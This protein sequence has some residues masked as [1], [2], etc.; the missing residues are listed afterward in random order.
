MARVVVLR[1]DAPVDAGMEG[2]HPAAKHLRRTGV[3]RHQDHVQA[4]LLEHPGGAAAADQP[5][6]VLLLQCPRK[7]NKPGFVRDAEQCCGTHR[8]G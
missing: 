8:R 4:G 5:E 7:G 3:I 6:A 1:Q 2:L